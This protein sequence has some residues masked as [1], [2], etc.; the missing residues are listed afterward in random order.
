[1]AKKTYQQKKAEAID[2]AIEWQNNFEKRNYS[3][4]EIA[5]WG[6]HFEKLARRYGLIRE[7]KENG[8]I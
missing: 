6:N 4:G 3:W 2:E 8:I 1:M 7:F 5:F